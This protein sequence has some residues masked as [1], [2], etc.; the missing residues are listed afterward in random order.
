MCLGVEVDGDKEVP[1][2]ILTEVE[3]GRDK[4][5]T[6]AAFPPLPPSPR[7]HN[8]ITLSPG[9]ARQ[10]E[11][12]SPQ[13]SSNKRSAGNLTPVAREARLGPAHQVSPRLLHP[14]WILRRNCPRLRRTVPVTRACYATPGDVNSYNRGL[15]V[16][17]AAGSRSWL[18]VSG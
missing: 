6:I 4:K 11:G 18:S 1:N 15:L 3:E 2:I 8:A 14:G 9:L 17:G 10:C 12:H 16:G 13:L 5:I 7:C